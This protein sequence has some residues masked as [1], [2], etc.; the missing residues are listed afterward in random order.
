MVVPDLEIAAREYIKALDNG[1]ATA[2][3][4]FLGDATH[5]GIY[6]RSR[7][8]SGLLRSIWGNS[9]HLWMWDKYSLTQELINA[10]FRDVRI[11]KFNDCDDKMFNYVEEIYRFDKAVTIECKK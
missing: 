2:S 1:D 8:L 4:T 6:K 11:C 10:G 5:L 9:H 3:F 7:G